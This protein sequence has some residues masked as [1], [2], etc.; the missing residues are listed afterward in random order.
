M[1]S[2]SGCAPGKCVCSSC[3][4][5][6]VD[7]YLLKVTGPEPSPFLW[8][9]PPPPG[10]EGGPPSQSPPGPPA[11]PGEPQEPGPGGSGGTAALPASL[12]LSPPGPPAAQ[13][14]LPSPGGRTLLAVRGP[15]AFVRGA[16]AGEEPRLGCSVSRGA[17]GCS[18]RGGRSG[19][20]KGNGL[21]VRHDP[22]CAEP[23]LGERP[24][25]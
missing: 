18:R 2:G 25:H 21:S 15:R 8:R 10:P 24:E 6:I 7:K 23:G 13:P 5:E 16:G 17:L 22:R 19:E 11:A 14:P 12:R 4:L 1:A 9:P 3:G 20:G